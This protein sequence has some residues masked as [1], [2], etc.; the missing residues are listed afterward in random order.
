MWQGNATAPQLHEWVNVTLVAREAAALITFNI[1]DQGWVNVSTPVPPGRVGVAHAGLRAYFR[2]FVATDATT[3]LVLGG[4]GGA[5]E[6]VK[7]RVAVVRRYARALS[8]EDV[9]RN[10]LAEVPRFRTEMS[11]S[12]T[13]AWNNGTAPTT[14]VVLPFNTTSSNG[15][16]TRLGRF[17]VGAVEAP[18]GTPV[19]LASSVVGVRL[20][21][22][23]EPAVI[24]SVT[25]QLSNAPGK[26]ERTL[27]CTRV[28]R[29][30]TTR[31]VPLQ[32]SQGQHVTRPL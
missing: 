9:A 12:D 11:G 7:A 3:G 1:G 24:E 28:A 23:F 5:G 29:L 25:L 32:G 16:T 17:A 21:D 18:G 6:G 27:A 22:D 26:C 31:V 13:P 15:A 4:G 2:S 30:M 14:R 19:R 10:Y 8:P 20:P